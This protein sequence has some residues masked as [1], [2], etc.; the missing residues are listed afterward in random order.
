M[1]WA[2]KNQKARA[3]DDS[4]SCLVIW[5]RDISVKVGGNQLGAVA[6]GEVGGS[7]DKEQ[8][9]RKEAA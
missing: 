5:R 8:V 6:C 1:M 9:G 4:L 7:I 2:G 3:L